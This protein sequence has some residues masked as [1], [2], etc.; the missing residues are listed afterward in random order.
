MSLHL[1]QKYKIDNLET[2]CGKLRVLVASQMMENL[3]LAFDNEGTQSSVRVKDISK[4]FVKIKC[5][6]I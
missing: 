6:C 2:Q 3:S 1:S 4:L 5:Q